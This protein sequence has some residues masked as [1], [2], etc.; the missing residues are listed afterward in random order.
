MTASIFEI[1]LGSNETIGSDEP[2]VIGGH[3]FGLVVKVSTLDTVEDIGLLCTGRR[4]LLRG[5]ITRPTQDVGETVW[6]ARSSRDQ[7]DLT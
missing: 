4:V 2:R 5:R 7:L 6:S 3:S 1:M